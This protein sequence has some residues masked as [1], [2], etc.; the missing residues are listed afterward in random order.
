MNKIYVAVIAEDGYDP[1][2]YPHAFN[3]FEEAKN[4]L[5]ANLKEN[6]T[7]QS[8]P[9]YD[10]DEIDNLDD[11]EFIIEEELAHYNGTSPDFQYFINEIELS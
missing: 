5:L 8:F 9:D 2:V 6:Y 11:C 7:C 1:C 4:E 3:S 10:A